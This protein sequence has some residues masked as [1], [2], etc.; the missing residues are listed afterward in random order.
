MTITPADREMAA[1]IL[2]TIATLLAEQGL[3]NDDEYHAYDR[4][5]AARNELGASLEACE[6]ARRA[7]R[8]VYLRRDS[9]DLGFEEF[10]EAEALVRAGWT[11]EAL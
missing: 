11:P 4:L 6:L 1:N 10:A 8:R 9:A 5:I 7:V 2:S 3:V